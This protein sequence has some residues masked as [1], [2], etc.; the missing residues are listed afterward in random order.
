MLQWFF[1]G[2]FRDFIPSLVNLQTPRSTKV[3]SYSSTPIRK[4]SE[5]CQC[6][7]AYRYPSFP[8]IIASSSTVVMTNDQIEPMTMIL[9]LEPS[10]PLLHISKNAD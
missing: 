10:S 1:L 8:F 9:A 6:A 2:F 3:V 5:W 7:K 4:I